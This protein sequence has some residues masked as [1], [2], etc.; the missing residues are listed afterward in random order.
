VYGTDE[1]LY[2]SSDPYINLWD[3]GRD[4]LQ[5]GK[6]RIKLAEG[7]MGKLA[8]TAVDKGESYAR[9]RIAFSM[10]L[11]QYGDAAYLA[12]QYVGGAA[13][14][15][16]HKGDPDGRDPLVPVDGAKQREALAFL[17]KQILTDKPF[18]FPPDL[19]RKLGQE[20]WYH[21][22]STDFYFGAAG[23]FPVN[24]RVLGIQRI[25]LDELLS[26]ATLSRLQNQAR[27][28]GKGDKP[29][30]PA[31]VFR[32]LSDGVFGDLKGSSVVSR[33]LQ[34][35]YLQ[36]L[37]ELVLGPKNDFGRYFFFSLRS[38]SGVPADAKALAR[39]HLRETGEK[40]KAALGEKGMEDDTVKAHL[41]EMQERIA[42]VLD[43]RPAVN[44]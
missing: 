33:N 36:K 9:L 18:A 5:F 34:R 16:D 40:I 7:L 39:L 27:T 22:G 28:A 11:Y 17:Q 21:W 19:L 24:E 13:V 23:E 38:A 2:G 42:K 31:E 14:Y 29:L 25:A 43:A 30:T 44:D 8:T 37:A 12:S 10:L 4:P 1:D 32:A 35:A 6:D 3:L 41:L 20:K 15:R 26:G